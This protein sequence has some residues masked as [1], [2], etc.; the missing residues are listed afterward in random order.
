MKRHRHTPEQVVRKLREGERILNEG[1]DP[2]DRGAA[3]LGD[4]RGDVEP[5]AISVRR[6]EGQR[7]Q[8]AQGAGVRERPVEEVGG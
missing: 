8:A 2:P 4:L 3:Y 7:G 1:K 6:D 5:L